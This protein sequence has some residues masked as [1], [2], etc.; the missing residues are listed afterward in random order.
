M[1]KIKNEHELDM[2]KAKSS[3]FWQDI[4]KI[5]C[6]ATIGGI[7]GGGAVYHFRKDNRIK[8]I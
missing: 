1:Q 4:V 6:V 5:F 8:N 3:N 7:I 2:E